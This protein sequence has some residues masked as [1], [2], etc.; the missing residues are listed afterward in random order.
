MQQETDQ[1]PYEGASEQQ[2]RHDPK[3][4]Q[5]SNEQSARIFFAFLS[6]FIAL[7]LLIVFLNTPLDGLSKMLSLLGV[8]AFGMLGFILFDQGRLLKNT[9]SRTVKQEEQE[10]WEPEDEKRQADEDHEGLTPF[11]L[12]VREALDSIPEEFHKQMDNLLVM[13]ESEP[14]NETLERTDIEEGAIL[15]GLY[16]GVPLTAPGYDRTL[17]PKRITLYQHNIE[18]YCQ[19]DPTRIR[20]QVR[21]TLLH[22]VAHHFGMDHDEMPIWIR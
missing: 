4:V 10:P 9:L 15:L 13:V 1:A 21:E 8:L 6:F 18:A 22:E 20:E 19:G 14:D 11:E 5:A 3:E 7:I 12:L 17:L 16:Q 2:N